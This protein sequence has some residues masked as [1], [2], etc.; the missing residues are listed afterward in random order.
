LIEA[1]NGRCKQHQTLALLGAFIAARL[2]GLTAL[3]GLFAA[4]ESHLTT[5]LAFVTAGEPLFA[6]PGLGLGS[7]A[8][9]PFRAAIQ[10]RG[11]AISGGVSRHDIGAGEQAYRENRTQNQFGKHEGSPVIRS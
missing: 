10:A 8:G 2:G 1:I 3:A 9:G 5:G 7:A 6:A 4:R 11:A